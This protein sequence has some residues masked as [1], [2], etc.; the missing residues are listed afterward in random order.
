MFAKFSYALLVGLSLWQCTF[1]QNMKIDPNW[2]DELRRQIADMEVKLAA[3]KKEL[4]ETDPSA[5]PPEKRKEFIERIQAAYEITPSMFETKGKLLQDKLEAIKSAGINTNLDKSKTPNDDGSGKYVFKSSSDKRSMIKKIGDEIE[6][7]DS[8]PDKVVQLKTWEKIKLGRAEIGSFGWENFLAK[9]QKLTGK[10]EA[11]IGV[12]ERL[13][14][15]SVSRKLINLYYFT[16]INT[17]DLTDNSYVDL[18]G[19]FYVVGTK[20]IDG[21]TLKHLVKFN[22]TNEERK[23]LDP[24]IKK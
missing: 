17:T 23:A 8:Y 6:S 21:V 20:N 5:I 7:Y 19:L 13:S 12:Y 9:P 22:L 11:I 18:A 15:S 4:G 3:L 1:G 2:A 14:D 24:R 10:D 16:G